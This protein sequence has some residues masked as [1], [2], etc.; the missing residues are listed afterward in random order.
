MEQRELNGT[1]KS[2]SNR[3]N[4]SKA[5]IFISED[6]GNIINPRNIQNRVISI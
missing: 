3:K 4:T 6:N 5:K 1:W 2:R